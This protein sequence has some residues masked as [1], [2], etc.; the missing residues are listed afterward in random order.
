MPEIQ[1]PQRP[2][3]SRFVEDEA[4]ET[5]GLT[6]R[7]FS[8]CLTLRTKEQRVSLPM[9]DFHTMKS[10]TA[11]GVYRYMYLL[12][13][14]YLHCKSHTSQYTQQTTTKMMFSSISCIEDLS[15]K[16]T[17]KLT[18]ITP[19]N[20]HPPS[21]NPFQSSPASHWSPPSANKKPA[22]ASPTKHSTPTSFATSSFNSP[23]NAPPIS[24]AWF[25]IQIYLT[26]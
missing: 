26:I 7:L 9:W 6:M 12:M 3:H 19:R 11:R 25:Q 10:Q 14:N 22:C 18:Q 1:A 4:V 5:I 16:E 21:E 24:H 2:L 17:E 8:N 23:Q 15:P 13:E 20:Y